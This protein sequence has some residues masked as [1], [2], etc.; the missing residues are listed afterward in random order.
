MRGKTVSGDCIYVV[1]DD[2]VMSMLYG[3]L[4]ETV[5]VP[6][7]FF[8]SGEAFFAGWSADWQGG[9]LLDLQMPG[10]DGIEVLQRLRAIGSNLVVVVVTGFGEIRST[11]EAMKLGAMDY[12]EKPFDHAEFI[13]AVEEMLSQ[14]RRNIAALAMRNEASDAL[15][16]LTTREREIG[17]LIARGMT[18]QQIARILDISP[19]TID[20]HRAHLLVKLNCASSVELAAFFGR[21]SSP[22]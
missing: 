22:P 15:A 8:S 14:S 18:S 13:S 10:M 12:L 17:D 5:G 7:V 4:L 2:P 1:E 21:F 9:V 20:V 19:R 16:T 6:A 11:V 3:E